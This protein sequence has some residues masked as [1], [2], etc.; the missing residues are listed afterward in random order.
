M[1]LVKRNRNVK[2]TPDEKIYTD[3][4]KL[5]KFNLDYKIRINFCIK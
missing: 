3:S 4:N 2:N 1:N 5:D